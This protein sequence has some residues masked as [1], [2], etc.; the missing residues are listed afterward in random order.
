MSKAKKIVVNRDDEPKKPIN[1]KPMLDSVLS[2]VAL[3]IL[4]GLAYEGVKALVDA[5]PA[6]QTA[7]GILLVLLLIKTAVKK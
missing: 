5:K 2:Y 4:A 7:V 6:V 1:Y 3:V